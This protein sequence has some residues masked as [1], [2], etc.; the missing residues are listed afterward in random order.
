MSFNLATMLHESALAS[1]EKPCVI[2]DDTTVTYAQ[3]EQLSGLVAGNLRALGLEPGDK[4]AVQLPNLPHFLF[5]Y[6]GIMRAGLV[7]VPL[8]PLLRGPEI[9][10]HLENSDARMLLTF[11][12][13]AEEAHR[14]A[15]AVPGMTTYVV[16]VSD[17]PRP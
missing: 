4:V 9:S 14:A 15:R 17:V 12:L 8:N 3:V 7:M 16:E 2:I 1:P 6:F 13:I 11:D 10:Y 5:A